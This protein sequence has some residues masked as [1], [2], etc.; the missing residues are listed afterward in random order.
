MIKYRGMK[1]LDVDNFVDDVLVNDKPW[2][3]R[4]QE[5]L[6][7]SHVFV[8]AHGSRDKRCGVCGPFLIDMF[9]EEAELRGS[10]NQVFVT[11]C[12]HIGGHKYTGN[13]IVYSPGSDGSITCDIPHRPGV[14]GYVT[15]EDVLELGQME[16]SSDEAEEINDQEL[17]NGEENKKIEEKPQENGNQIHQEKGNQI[18]NSEN[19]SGCC[20]GANSDVFTCCKEVSLEENNGSEEKKTRE[21]TEL[22]ARKDS[23]GK[24]SSLIRSWEQSDVLTVVAVVGAVATVAVAYSFYRK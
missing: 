10:T 9:K 6:T 21:T 15:P 19:F 13:L 4:V 24:L 16:A 8:C 17:P 18:E 2:A 7:G 14:Y 1:E 12:S 11:A 5:T 20:Q 3:S 23:L 22:C